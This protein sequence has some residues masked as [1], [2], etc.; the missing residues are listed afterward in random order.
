MRRISFYIVL[1]ML[2]LFLSSIFLVIW[3]PVKATLSEITNSWVAVIM[4]YLFLIIFLYEKPLY[5]LFNEFINFRNPAKHHSQQVNKKEFLGFFSDNNFISSLN[6]R[7]P[8]WVN[9]LDKINSE[10]GYSAKLNNEINEYMQELQTK[11]IKWCFLFAD[12]YLVV[13]AKYILFWFYKFKKVSFDCFH[14]V[15]IEK[16]SDFSER[17]AILKA[18]LNLEFLEEDEN[19]VFITELG[20]TYVDY[21]KKIDLQI[22]LEK[23]AIVS[24]EKDDDGENEIE[25]DE[26][27]GEDII[28]EEKEEP[29]L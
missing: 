26:I 28:D 2:F 4:V 24:E 10:N 21:L 16:I 22:N 18:L 6:Y 27:Q 11:R 5:V 1:S 13:Q 3:W 9:I 23:H 15:W 8:E 7:N 19:N 25:E 12:I 14:N 20:M 29:D 17:D